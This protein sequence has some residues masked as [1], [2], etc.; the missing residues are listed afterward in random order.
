[1]NNLFLIVKG[2]FMGI[3]EVIPGVSGGT[4]AF[5][6]GIYEKLLNT[7]KA[8][9]TP[10]TWSHILQ[11][12]FTLFWQSIHG[13][14]LSKLLL[15][16][17]GGL[18]FG[19]LFFTYLLESF[20]ILI[21]AFFFGLIISSSFYIGR[22]V[23]SWSLI[24][25]FVLLIGI[26]IAYGITLLNPGGGS[27]SLLFVFFS[28]MIAISALILPGIS[29]SFILLLMGMYP[30]ILG[31][32]KSVLTDFNSE[33]LLLLSIFALG[34]LTGLAL[35]SRILSYAFSNFPNNT[36]ALLTGFMLGSL[37]KIWPW[38]TVL[39]TRI[40]SKGEEVPFLEKPIFPMDYPGD[41]MIF[42]ALITFLGGILLVL[43]FSYLEKN[44]R[45]S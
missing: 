20:P 14:F 8:F 24:Q 45:H 31:A 11:G 13:S 9:L 39:E 26:S 41:P 19:V 38:R 16:M 33:N 25:V 21:W 10:D 32:A 22:K 35:F 27:S 28:G 3:A 6:T 12:K 34:C 40:N 1:M 18:V 29:G 43:I 5:I 42:G 23:K 44:F 15:G 30:I 17:I 37:P 4:I 2:F 36:L 7:I